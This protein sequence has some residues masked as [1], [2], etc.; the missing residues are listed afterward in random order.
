VVPDRL[1]NGPDFFVEFFQRF[2]ERCDGW[3]DFFP[4]LLARFFDR[5]PECFSS[6]LAGRPGGARSTRCAG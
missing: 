4:K 1:E 6:F 2:F 5:F 3:A